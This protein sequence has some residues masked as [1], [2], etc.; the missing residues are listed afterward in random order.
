MTLKTEP[1]PWMQTARRIIEE[2]RPPDAAEREVLLSALHATPAFRNPDAGRKD[3]ALALLPVRGDLDAESQLTLALV[4]HD[5]DA[6]LKVLQETPDM[7][8]RLFHALCT[9]APSVRRWLLK[10]LSGSFC[11]DNAEKLMLDFARADFVALRDWAAIEELQDLLGSLLRVMIESPTWGSFHKDQASQLLRLLGRQAPVLRRP[12][13]KLISGAGRVLTAPEQDEEADPP[14]LRDLLEHLRRRGVTLDGRIVH[15]EIRVG[16]VTG[17]ITYRAPAVQTWPAEERARRIRPEPGAVFVALDYAQIEPLIMLNVLV[18]RLWLAIPD[19]PVH[20]V[21]TWFYPEDR[22]LGK[23]IVNRIINGGSTALVDPRPTLLRFVRAVEMFRQEWTEE[24]RLMGY[25][26]SLFGRRMPFPD[27]PN[28][29]GK[30]VNR[31]IQGTAADIFNRAA[32][33]IHR[34]QSEGNLP[35][36]VALLLFDEIWIQTPAEKEQE[37]RRVCK[38][39]MKQSARRVCLYRTP[40]VRTWVVGGDGA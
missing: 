27:P 1:L 40:D 4:L 11:R 17:R 39:I 3:A 15:P 2:M 19:L 18:Q 25:A 28:V 36:E 35:G 21:Y 14:L 13:R 34:R 37:V 5:W 38:E 20:D 12:A 33:E 24:C 22:A 6:V 9:E 29:P 7:R 8:P 23:Q 10:K 26:P 31:L 30:L 16:T 32:E